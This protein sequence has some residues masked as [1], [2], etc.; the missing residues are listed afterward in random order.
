MAVNTLPLETIY[1]GQRG[2]RGGSPIISV[3]W[4]GHVER[5][6]LPGPSHFIAKHSQSFEWGYA[7][8]GPAQLALALLLDFTRD[9]ETSQRLYQG[10]KDAYVSGWPPAGFSISGAEIVAWVHKQ[11][12]VAL[13]GDTSAAD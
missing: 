12:S 6:L 8:S 3:Q 2:G 13:G 7:G 11:N 1:K 10:F 9:R 4:H 5:L